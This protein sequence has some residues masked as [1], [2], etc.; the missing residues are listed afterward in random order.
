MALCFVEI[1]FLKRVDVLLSKET[2]GGYNG[3][4][5]NEHILFSNFIYTF[6]QLYI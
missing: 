6:C 2:Q 4:F 1:L 5:Q 3:S